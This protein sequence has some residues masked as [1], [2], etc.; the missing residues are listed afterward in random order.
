[1]LDLKLDQS[2]NVV[3]WQTYRIIMK[4]GIDVSISDSKQSLIFY[5][6]FLEKYPPLPPKI[7][8]YLKNKY[9]FVQIFTYRLKHTSIPAFGS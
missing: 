6:F 3:V 9:A 2:Y 5:D 1:M 8:K 7:E 4:S